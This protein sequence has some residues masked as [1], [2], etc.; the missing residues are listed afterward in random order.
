[1]REW[2][3]DTTDLVVPIAAVPNSPTSGLTSYATLGLSRFDNSFT[4]AGGQ[5]LRV[6]F[7]L[8]AAIGNTFAENGLGNCA[9][10]VATGDYRARPG[11]IYP[12]VF[13][14]YS[15][16][17]TTPHGLLWYSYSWGDDFDALD[18]EVG[19]VEWLQIVPITTQELDFVALNGPGF[20]G[21][22]VEK[23]LE[24]FEAAETVMWD[25]SRG[26]AV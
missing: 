23:L 21:E 14:G 7:L 6:E 11:A 1:M 26:S 8:V 5:P 3:S 17:V 10:N 19:H 22:G 2:K 15:D 25:F 16:S 24:A 13:A 20:E 12:N 18:L 4:T 9:L